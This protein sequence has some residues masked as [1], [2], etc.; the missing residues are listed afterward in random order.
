VRIGINALYL[1]PGR[2]GGTETY[3]RNLVKTLARIDDKNEYFIFINSESVGVFDNAGPRMK[4]VPCAFRAA[5]RPVR[6]LWEQ[7]ILPLQVRR[8]GIDVL[9]GAGMTAPF[10][11][12]APSVLTIHDLQHEVHPENFSRSQLFFLK[13]IIGMSA[14]RAERILCFSKKVRLDIIKY[15]HIPEDRINV[16]HHAADNKA[17]YRR[18]A[19]DVKGVRERYS[20]PERFI[21]YLASSLPHKNYG[22]LLG[23]FKMV[24]KDYPGL[25]LVLI[26]ARDYGAPVIREKIEK[27]GIADNVMMLNW[28]PFE[29]IPLIYSASSLLVFPSLHEGFGLPIIEAMACGVPVV[30]SN[31]EPMIEVAGGAARLVDPKSEASIAGGIKKVLGDT[32]LRRSL[33]QQGLRR[34]K[35]FTW[36]KTAMKTLS[37]LY[38]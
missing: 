15:Y 26:G 36:E 34:A 19:D 18:D 11:T 38:P 28:L 35:D 33:V 32:D 22:R 8:L 14:R 5:R 20:L 13:K 24:L 4:V 6:I 12:T 21:L 2:V 30:C 29:D 9:F 3:I 31:M 27:L 37:L 17:F 1:I 23:A 10:F 25:S 16:V 7:F